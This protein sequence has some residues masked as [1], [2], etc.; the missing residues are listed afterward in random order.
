MLMAIRVAICHM[1]E[2]GIVLIFL[3]TVGCCC[4][5]F[6]SKAAL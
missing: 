5:F 3:L 6:S 2:T 1:K 4:S